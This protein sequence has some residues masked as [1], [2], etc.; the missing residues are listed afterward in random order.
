MMSL[1]E[2][3]GLSARLMVEEYRTRLEK[4]IQINKPKIDPMLPL[5]TL[6]PD[7][8]ITA[9][10][11]AFIRKLRIFSK[12]CCRFLRSDYFADT[13]MRALLFLWSFVQKDD[14]TKLQFLK[15][16]EKSL[17]N[18][19]PRVLSLYVRTLEET[20]LFNQLTLDL[21]NTLFRYFIP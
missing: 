9:D 4:T 11:Y 8:R 15:G 6:D 5:L 18:F 7:R 10:L 20:I 1:Q 19:T 12:Y 2:E 13:F 16:L 14:A 21:S 17:Q 3:I